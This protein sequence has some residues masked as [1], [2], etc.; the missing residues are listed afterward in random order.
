MPGN[1]ATGRV[2]IVSAP[3]ITMTMEITMATMGRLMKNF[4]MG[5]FTLRFRAERLG[6]HPHA[7]AHLLDSFR[8]HAFAW[9]QPFVNNPLR[10]RALA[11]RDRPD[12]HDV[13]RVHDS[14]LITPL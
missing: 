10:A 9:L 12:G 4:D 14:H 13:L 6:V 8:N 5:L 11:G 1:C 2:R 7:R 3:T